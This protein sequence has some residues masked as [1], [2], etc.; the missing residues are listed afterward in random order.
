MKFP[1]NS[2]IFTRTCCRSLQLM[3]QTHTCTPFIAGFICSQHDVMCNKI[4]RTI[5]F[6]PLHLQHFSPFHPSNEWLRRNRKSH[7]MPDRYI[8]ERREKF[9]KN[10]CKYVFSHTRWTIERHCKIG[11]W[12]CARCP[13]TYCVPS[14]MNWR[15]Q[16]S[17][18]R[19]SWVVLFT[20]VEKRKASFPLLARFI[21]LLS[22]AAS[23]ALVSF[24]LVF[25]L[26]YVRAYEFFIKVIIYV[27]AAAWAP[28]PRWMINKNEMK[29]YLRNSM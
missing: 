1:A 10:Y 23:A 21:F 11:R 12:T 15:K 28:K 25:G 6:V 27:N 17:S 29:F 19:K 26:F 9:T 16:G 4:I 2:S 13:S 8:F 5:S 18:M 3:T 24:C 20:S 22:S 14:P 7:E